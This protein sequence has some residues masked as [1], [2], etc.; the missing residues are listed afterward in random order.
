LEVLSAC[1]GFRIRT[2][3]G[4]WHSVGQGLVSWLKGTGRSLARLVSG[5]RTILINGVLSWTVLSSGRVGRLRGSFCKTLASPSSSGFCPVARQSSVPVAGVLFP[6]GLRTTCEE[7]P[8]GILRSTVR[9]CRVVESSLLRGSLSGVALEGC[10]MGGAPSG[11]LP[12]RRLLVAEPHERLWDGTSPR[13][14]WKE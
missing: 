6:G 11:S 1:S 8:S 9:L 14:F 13:G 5:Q 4:V 2:G 12:A 3:A 10:G 7:C